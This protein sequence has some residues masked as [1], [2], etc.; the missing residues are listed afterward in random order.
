M[1]SKILIA[2]SAIAVGLIGA[3]GA[4]EAQT[5]SKMGSEAASLRSRV[6]SAELVN[7]ATSYGKT[8]AS[9]QAQK[10]VRNGTN[11]VKTARN[12]TSSAKTASNSTNTAKSARNSTNSAKTVR[13][14]HKKVPPRGVDQ[15]VTGSVGARSETCN[16]RKVDLFDRK[17]NF[18]KNERMRVCT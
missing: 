4:V 13:T 18:V 17:G 3:A 8:A 6:Q 1:K 2:V 14:A 10:V 11:S 7:K 9:E 12:S 5:L 15:T 16:V